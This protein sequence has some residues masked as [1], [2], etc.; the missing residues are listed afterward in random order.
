[1]SC[2]QFDLKGYFLGELTEPDRRVVEEHAQT[3]TECREELARLSVTRAALLSV[4]DEDMPRRI[5]FVS[6]KVFEQRGWRW[7]W[8]SAPRLGFASAAMLAA[9]I[10]V[11]AFVRP[12][13]VV[14]PATVDTA[15][16][17]ARVESEVFQRLH[18]A[19]EK[20]VAES[21]ARQAREMAELVSAVERRLERQRQADLLAVEENFKVLQKRVNV[22]YRASSDLGGVR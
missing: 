9:A 8:N 3:C 16:L 19:L 13:P 20:V 5:A 6:D 11:H 12:A 22:F 7:L 10:M 2:S 18:V 15:A 21:D 17:E 1:M 14:A 4:R